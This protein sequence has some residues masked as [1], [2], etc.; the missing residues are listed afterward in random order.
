V[1]Q[2]ILHFQNLISSQVHEALNLSY[3]SSAELNKMIDVELPK[4]RPSFTRTEVV[5]AGEA[6]DLFK[7]PLLECIRSLYGAPQHAQYLCVAPERHYSDPDKTNRLYHDMYTGK[8]WWST[9]VGH[10]SGA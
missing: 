7:R 3:R 2:I 8:W 10:F 5:V 1:Y 6:F 4:Q 9:Q